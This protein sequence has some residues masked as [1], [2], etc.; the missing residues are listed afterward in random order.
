MSAWQIVLVIFAGLW[1]ISAFSGE[2]RDGA[3]ACNGIMLDGHCAPA[4]SLPPETR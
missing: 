1:L 4:P 2:G 3:A